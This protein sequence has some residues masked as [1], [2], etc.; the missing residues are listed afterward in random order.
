M[1]PSPATLA[2]FARLCLAEAA[3]VE[4]TEIG[5]TERQLYSEPDQPAYLRRLASDVDRPT[6]LHRRASTLAEA[7]ELLAARGMPELAQYL[8]RVL[9]PN[10]HPDRREALL[11]EKALLLFAGTIP[12]AKAFR[13]KAP[14]Q[15][16]A[17]L[18]W[19]L[20]VCWRGRAQ[21]LRE[22][23]RRGRSAPASKICE[24]CGQ[25]YCD[26]CPMARRDEMKD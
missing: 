14:E 8:C 12:G 10:V 21:A 1:S 7:Q 23:T 3:W 15:V 16:G 25:I 6:Y 22:W 4:P 9:L 24:V 13:E 20:E 19:M 2:A 17:A 26:G 5:D 18:R 11:Q